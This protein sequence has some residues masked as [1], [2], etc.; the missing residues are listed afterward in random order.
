MDIYVKYHMHRKNNL[1]MSGLIGNSFIF[2]LTP[3]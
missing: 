2:G 1:K 3:D